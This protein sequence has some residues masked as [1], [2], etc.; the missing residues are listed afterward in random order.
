MTNQY[1]NKFAASF[2]C[3]ILAAGKGTRMKS[4][5]PKVM[6]QIAGKPLIA[7]V[8]STLSNLSPEKTIIV[9]S[10][11]PEMESVRQAVSKIAADAKFVVQ[12]EQLGTGHAVC[13][14]QLEL[15][16]HNSTILVLYGDTP[17]ITVQTL[18][19]ILEKSQ[20][21]EVV[22]LGMRMRNP[23][24]YGRL[25]VSKDEK[26]EKI[27]ED[28]DTTPEQ[29]SITLCNSGVMAVSGKHLF[30]LL[31][32]LTPTNKAG[33]Y[34]LTDIVAF[35]SDMGIRCQVVEADASELSGINTREQLADAEAVMQQRLRKVAMAGGVTMIDPYSVYL[36]YDTKIASDVIIHPHVV[37]G[38]GVTVESGV[39]IRSFSY[40]EG[41]RIKANAI[42]GP[43]ARL[44]AGS[45]IGENAHIG[46]FVE[47]KNSEIGD[48]AKANH[49]SYVGDSEVGAGANIGAG[50]ITCNY[51]GVNKHKTTIGAGAFIGSNTSLVAPVIIGERA[52]VGAGSVITSDVPESAL[53][54]ERSPQ[55]NKIGRAKK[56]AKK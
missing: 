5:L 19:K 51:D 10:P 15:I 42:V 49:L 36:R 35:A 52:M 1:K 47:I 31:E 14:T 2:A 7:H 26:L 21:S 41:A 53:A 6:H 37:F 44:R 55:V 3:V 20:S 39:E 29:K 38:D 16:E 13:S 48:G 18:K 23:T 45:V 4:S 24:G 32:K 34:Y 56:V 33:E 43:F 12:K 9:V 27:I 40:I 22:V 17:L 8:V 25:L 54:I 28:R 50:T 11:D 30:T 46:N